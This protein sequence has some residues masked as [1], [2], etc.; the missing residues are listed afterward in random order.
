MKKKEK[1]L[2]NK[3]INN[4]KYTKKELTEFLTNYG[5]YIYRIKPEYI[6]EKIISISL[7]TLT[8]LEGFFDFIPNKILN[9]DFLTS[10]ILKKP[11]LL[12]Y[13]PTDIL[14]AS[15]IEYLINKHPKKHL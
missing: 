15:F 7:N 4:E 2:L 1:E 8:K 12:S 14:T 6:D 5:D 10:I 11:E 9:D 13:I 3:I